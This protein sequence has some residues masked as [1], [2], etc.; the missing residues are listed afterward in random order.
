MK[1]HLKT[2]ALTLT[3]VSVVT[4]NQ[5]VFSLVKEPILKQTQAFSSISGADYAESSGKSKLK[6][7]ETSGPVDDTVTD[8]FSDKRTTPE[9]IKDNLAKGP[10]EQELKAVT[11]NTESEKQ[12]TSGSQLEQS[13]ESLSLNKTVLNKTVPSTSNWEICDFITKGN[14]LVGLSKSGVEK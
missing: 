5:E 1:K 13:K 3:T 4:H 10:R 9:K 2:V 12:I 6:I 11:E 14:T 8:L 7:N